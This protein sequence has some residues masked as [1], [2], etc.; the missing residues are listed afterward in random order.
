MTEKD[1]SQSGVS[2]SS[3]HK[4]DD[5]PDANSPSQRSGTGLLAVMQ[6][7]G[8]AMLGVQSS[9]NKERDFTHGKPW[10]FVIGGLVGTLLFLLAIGLLVTY[11]I[12]IS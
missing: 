9:K 10:H 6:S 7:V 12:E 5:A 4:L 3:N 1:S 2:S 11:L 8:A